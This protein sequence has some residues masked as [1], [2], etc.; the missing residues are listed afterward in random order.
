M[1]SPPQLIAERR[2]VAHLRSYGA[3]SPDK[4]MGFAP[5]RWSHARALARLRD[6]G[7]VKG[8]DGALW[9][10]QAAWDQRR[11]QQ[12]KKALA[13]LTLGAVSAGIA[14]ITTLRG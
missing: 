7:V 8:E 14:A 11:R 2:V 13:L 3:L 4:V 12:R 6:A 10:D 5:I 1:A 9:L